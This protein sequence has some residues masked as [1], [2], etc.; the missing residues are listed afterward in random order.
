[1]IKENDDDV[2]VLESVHGGS[3]RATL[4][5]FFKDKLALKIFFHNTVLSPGATGGFHKHLDSE[6]IYYIIS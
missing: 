3:G 6:E 4:H 1:M 5:N 2:V